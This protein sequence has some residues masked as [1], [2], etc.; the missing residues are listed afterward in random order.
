MVS[1]TKRNVQLAAAF[2]ALA[3]RYEANDWVSY[4]LWET[5]EGARSRPFV[6]LDPLT[7][8]E[9]DMLRALRDEAGIWFFWQNMRWNPTTIADWRTHAATTRSEDILQA[10]Q[11]QGA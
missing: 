4:L 9:L 8:E 2:I 7:P 10:L 5:L 3:N 6:F 11:S 1:P